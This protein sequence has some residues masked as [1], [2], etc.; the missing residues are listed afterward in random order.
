MAVC[1][2]DGGTKGVCAEVESCSGH[3][4]G[5]VRS[6]SLDRTAFSCPPHTR[7]HTQAGHRSTQPTY[8]HQPH[9]HTVLASSARRLISLSQCRHTHAQS[10]HSSS[11]AFNPTP[12]LHRQIPSRLGSRCVGLPLILSLL[13]HLQPA[14]PRPPERPGTGEGGTHTGV[15]GMRRG[16]T[17]IQMAQTTNTEP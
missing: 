1:H 15:V 16:V 3:G 12:L 13:L 10:L 7:A 14:L 5:F 8:S 9:A 6:S 4:W 17:M 2:T 11:R